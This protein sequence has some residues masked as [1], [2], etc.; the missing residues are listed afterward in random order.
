MLYVDFSLCCCFLLYSSGARLSF[1]VKLSPS[2]EIAERKS[3]SVETD[4]FY[5]ALETLQGTEVERVRNILKDLNEGKVDAETLEKLVQ[6]Y[7]EKL[8]VV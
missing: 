3:L 4:I 2:K 8:H 5:E 6:E 1:A 7:E